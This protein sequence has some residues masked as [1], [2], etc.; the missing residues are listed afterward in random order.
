M[1]GNINPDLA[2]HQDGLRIERRIL[3]SG[4]NHIETVARNRAKEALRHL[5]PARIPGAEKQ[6]LCLN[7]SNPLTCSRQSSAA[8]SP[9]F[10]CSTRRTETRAVPA[11][12]PYWPNTRGRCLHA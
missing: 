10:G 4:A 2:H 3:A 7:H 11:G 9:C 5:C 1:T 8:L 12:L 6:D